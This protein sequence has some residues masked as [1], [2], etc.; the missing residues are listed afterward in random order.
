MLERPIWKP[1]VPSTFCL[2]LTNMLCVW[3]KGGFEKKKVVETKT[4]YFERKYGV[5]INQFKSTEDVDKFLANKI[6]R[7]LEAKDV[8][9]GLIDRSGNVFPT[10]ETNI[11]K[12]LNRALKIQ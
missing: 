12:D 8:N 5:D 1:D 10:R 2:L 9:N 11:D 6:G 7:T 4:V 3:N